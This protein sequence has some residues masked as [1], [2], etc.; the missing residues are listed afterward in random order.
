MFTHHSMLKT[1]ETTGGLTRFLIYH[2][3]VIVYAAAIIMVSSMSDLQ[4]PEVKFV[5]F[6]KVAHFVEYAIFAVLCYRSF[7]NIRS[8]SVLPRP[9]LMAALFVSIFAVFDE[10]YQSFVPGRSSDVYD[11]LADLS[12]ALLV[13][14][15][16]QTFHSRRNRKRDK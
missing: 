5:A 13:L 15:V 8:L 16:L 12:G 10:Y 7:A 1:A 14:I 9:F 3:P 4:T 11:A 2:L 6:D